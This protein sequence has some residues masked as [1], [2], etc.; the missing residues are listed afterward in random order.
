MFWIKFV[1]RAVILALVAWGVWRTALKARGEF[2]R[3]GI[4]WNELRWDWL[5][6]AMILYLVGTFPSCVFWWQTLRSMGQRP[7]FGE[8]L[9]AYYI[10]HLGKYVPGKAL[11]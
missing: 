9:R 10:G 5:A 6:L 3:E 11:V 7:A 8:T 1:A 2:A 4:A